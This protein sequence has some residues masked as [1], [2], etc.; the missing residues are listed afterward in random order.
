MCHSN[1][2]AQIAKLRYGLQPEALVEQ[3]AAVDD[4]RDRHDATSRELRKDQG[5]G[6]VDHLSL[7][8][9]L[10]AASGL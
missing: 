6:P 8:S 9:A 5:F 1:Y 2:V 10:A 4:D 3:T 7:V